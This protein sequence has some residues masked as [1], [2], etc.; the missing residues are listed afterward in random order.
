MTVIKS[1]DLVEA[2]REHLAKANP[3]VLRELVESFANAL[4]SASSRRRVWGTLWGDLP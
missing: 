1:M 2:V 4:M 3:D